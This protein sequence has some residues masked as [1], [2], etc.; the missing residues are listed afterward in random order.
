MK[1]EGEE[2][3]A[4]CLFPVLARLYF[5]ARSLLVS[6][7]LEP[8]GLSKEVTVILYLYLRWAHQSE[9]QAFVL[10][11]WQEEHKR[12]TLQSNGC[13]VSFVHSFRLG[14]VFV[15]VSA[16]LVLC[17]QTRSSTYAHWGYWFVAAGLVGSWKKGLRYY[18][19]SLSQNCHNKTIQK[20][21]FWTWPSSA[22]RQWRQHFG[23][24]QLLNLMTL[25]NALWCKI[26]PPVVIT[27]PRW[28]PKDL[29][30][31]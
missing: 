20:L 17:P 24:F 27:H 1:N 12:S 6:V 18:W 25:V 31:I 2:K 29:Y 9:R 3:R 26:I 4:F 14:H 21:A 23:I 28:M 22:E 8:V 5:R 15:K 16:E 10:V 30:L 19:V 11:Q 13:S 7:Y